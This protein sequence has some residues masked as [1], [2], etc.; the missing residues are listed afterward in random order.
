MCLIKHQDLKKKIN[1]YIFCLS[2]CNFHLIFFSP[3]LKKKK[4]LNSI[5]QTLKHQHSL[6]LKT[7]NLRFPSTI[8]KFKNNLK[9][10][11]WFWSVASRLYYFQNPP[12]PP[13][14][15]KIFL[16]TDF[17]YGWTIANRQLALVHCR[18]VTEFRS[19]RQACVPFFCRS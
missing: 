19:N 1:Y 16:L 4:A 5:S 15:R 14:G 7:S 2:R 11:G 12:P 8:S 9:S 17:V 13:D 10:L 6:E 18:S 3:R